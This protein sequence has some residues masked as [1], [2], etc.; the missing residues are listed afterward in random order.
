[1]VVV[2]EGA[3]GDKHLCAYLVPKAGQQPENH[4]LKEFLSKNLPDYMVPSYFV[5]V[6][7]IPLNRNGK[8]DRRA[9]P[10]PEIKTKTQYNAPRDNIEHK[11]VSLFTMV[12]DR[13][14]STGPQLPLIGIDDDFFELGGHSLKSTI[15]LMRI[16]K[17]L[18]V[19]IS[20]ADIFKY[21]TIRGLA[22]C[23]RQTSTYRYQ[24]L[25]PTEK[26]EY[27]PLTSAQKRLYIIR[28][29]DTQS[30]TY[31]VTHCLPLPGDM[32]TGKVIEAFRH[33]VA[34]HE[35]L[36]TSFHIINDQPVQ[37]IHDHID[38]V[39]EDPGPQFIRSF[40]PAHVPL[41]RVGCYLPNKEN[42]LL[43]LDMHHI[44]TDGVSFDILA[45]DFYAF[46]L[47]EG[48]KLPLLTVQ[49]K[50]FSAW[51]SRDEFQE[52]LNRQAAF[53][54]ETFH[55]K[56]PMAR[57]PIDEARGRSASRTGSSGYFD[58]SLT[59]EENH[60]IRDMARV[61]RSTTYMV[62]LAVFNILI[63]RLSGQED[64][65][66]GSLVTGR[67]H[68]ELENVTGMFV[69]TLALRN[70]PAGYKRFLAFL[71]EVTNRTVQAFDNQDFP[72]EE[73]VSRLGIDRVPGTTPLFNVMFVLQHPNT[74]QPGER[75]AELLARIPDLVN[76]LPGARKSKFDLTFYCLDNE[77]G[78]EFTIEYDTAQF[79][80]KSIERLTQYIHDILA[81]VAKN[82]DIHLDEIFL[83]HQ[84]WEEQLENPDIAFDI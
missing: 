31:N 72:F 13:Q 23:I 8:I 80:D 34:R 49:Y 45:R 25:E 47:E 66:I 38:W 30:I 39:I 19:K 35:S 24:S 21:P 37:R 70:Y 78:L 40:D 46:Y 41:F 67:L 15:L 62:L 5:F 52:I 63:S 68:L 57:L 51:Q 84:L 76:P 32:S 42:A 26:K 9:L 77:S 6:E 53:W 18:A 75:E 11:L 50:D 43:V 48:D 58:F 73:L 60:M 79:E 83:S 82:S 65:V 12:L 28:Q 14:V 20:L 74:R 22:A 44:I 81:Q 17:E 56:P 7:K 2:R 69:N 4:V 54:L 16:N 59:K 64:I 55:N 27:Y 61:H 36:R 71:A 10:E 29:L 3:E 33:L 1:V